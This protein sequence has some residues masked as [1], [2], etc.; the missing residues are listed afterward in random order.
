MKRVLQT[1]ILMML[2]FFFSV[3]KQKNH[4]VL[5]ASVA[6]NK[7]FSKL[8][9]GN[10]FQSRVLT[11]FIFEQNLST[12]AVLRRKINIRWSSFKQ[13][14]KI[15]A[16]ALSF[17]H[18]ECNL[19]A[20]KEVSEAWKVSLSFLFLQFINFIWNFCSLALRFFQTYT[21]ET[22]VTL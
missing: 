18:F 1:S 6:K 20:W 8:T 9:C 22:P 21:C 16:Q 19:C 5:G 12:H 13:F 2:L 7:R 11:S 4:P 3:H 15:I 17:K 14:G 10:W